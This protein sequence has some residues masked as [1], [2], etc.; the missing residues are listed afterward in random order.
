MNPVGEVIIIGLIAIGFGSIGYIA[1]KYD[2]HK[3]YCSSKGAIYVQGSD[4][5][6]CIKGEKL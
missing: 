6:L 2:A 4:G 3:E 5:W 1:G